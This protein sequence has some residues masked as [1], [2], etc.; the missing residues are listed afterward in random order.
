MKLQL[1]KRACPTCKEPLDLKIF[2]FSIQN[3]LVQC[4]KC[5]SLVRRKIMWIGPIIYIGGSLLA[6][7][8]YEQLGYFSIWMVA[9]LAIAFLIPLL[10]QKYEVIIRDFKIRNKLTNQ[11]TYIN[12]NDWQDIVANAKDAEP[13]FE[14]VEDL[15]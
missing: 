7:F 15:R 12:H 4:P 5:K 13:N 3:E 11:V 6:T 2:T 10:T 8:L 14:I 9:V 1:T